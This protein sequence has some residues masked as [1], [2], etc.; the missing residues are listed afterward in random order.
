M[1]E[2]PTAAWERLGRRVRERRLELG[3]SQ[4]EVDAVGGPSVGVLSK[5]E[6]GRQGY[7]EDRVFAAL[8]RALRWPAGSCT[9]I[10]H[11]RLPTQAPTP[12]QGA[13]GRPANDDRAQA[14]HERL[15]NAV[16]ER[17]LSLGKTWAEVATEAGITTETLRALRRGINEPNVLTKRGIERALGWKHGSVSAILDGGAPEVDSERV[18]V[19]GGGVMSARDIQREAVASRSGLV[20]ARCIRGRPA[21]DVDDVGVSSAVTVTGGEALCTEHVRDA[22]G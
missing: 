6:N 7:Y 14:A 19:V 4:A 20:C 8:E 13:A 3:L 16:D 11:D 18:A 1:A 12:E 17:R 21:I 9:E 22:L 2:S 5:I 10:L 15:S